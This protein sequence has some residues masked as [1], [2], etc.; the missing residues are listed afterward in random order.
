M[1]NIA[2]RGFKKG[3]R[4]FEEQVDGDTA[5]LEKL[6]CEHMTRLGEGPMM[7]EVEFLDEPDP[8]ERFLRFGTDPSGMV[9]PIA[10]DLT[11]LTEK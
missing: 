6:A 4:V 9:M 5:D 11:E 8:N 1:T 7:I 10:V 2:I 3:T